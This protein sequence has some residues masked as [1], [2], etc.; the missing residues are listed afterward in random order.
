MGCFLIFFCV[1][2]AGVIGILIESLG[3]FAEGSEW[4]M[5]LGF[6]FTLAGFIALGFYSDKKE[7]QKASLD[8]ESSDSFSNGK[9]LTNG[10]EADVMKRVIANGFNE[11]E[12]Y[13]EI[14]VPLITKRYYKCSERLAGEIYQHLIDDNRDKELIQIINEIDGLS[15]LDEVSPFAGMNTRLVMLAIQDFLNEYRRAGYVVDLESP[16]LITLLLLACFAVDGADPEFGLEIHYEYLLQNYSK[17][18]TSALNI[19]DTISSMSTHDPT[20]TKIVNM[21]NIY[22]TITYNPEAFDLKNGIDYSARLSEYEVL[23]NKFRDHLS[24]TVM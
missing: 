10:G 21:V 4:P 15:G 18:F 6:L 19:L 8:E 11:V 7:K 9:S 1:A 12:S 17:I 23:L 24:S 5:A 2:I 13:E 3:I 22:E 16:E 20:K 14:E